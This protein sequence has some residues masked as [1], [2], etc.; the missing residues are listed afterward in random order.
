MR[1]ISAMELDRTNTY[2]HVHV[3]AGAVNDYRRTTQL[4]DN[5]TQVCKKIGSNV[6]TDQ[7]LTQLGAEDQVH[8]NI[9]AGLRHVF[10]ALS[11]LGS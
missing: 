11:G 2:Q 3:I 7:R 8:N 4:P 6:W 1:A 5:A 10:F 9:A